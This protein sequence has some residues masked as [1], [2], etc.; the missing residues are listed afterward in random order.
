MLYQISFG[1]DTFLTR[2]FKA[3]GRSI[4]IEATIMPIINPFILP[5]KSNAPIEL[6]KAT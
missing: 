2:G 4:A 1:E 6:P 3:K 5:F